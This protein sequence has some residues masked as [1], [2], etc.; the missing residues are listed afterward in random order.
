[1]L[2]GVM[3]LCVAFPIALN[4]S[5]GGLKLITPISL[6]FMIFLTA[7]VAVRERECVCVLF[8]YR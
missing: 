2:L 7:I 6:A 1:M 4:R 8:A 5:L 3:L